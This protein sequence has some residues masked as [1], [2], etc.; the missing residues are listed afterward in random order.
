MRRPLVEILYF[1]GCPNHE[2]SRELVE[3][4]AAELRLQPAIEMVE[5]ADPEAAA[6]LRF[7]GSPS[8]RVDGRDV[9]PAAEQRDDFALA[10]RVYLSERGTA[11]Q[12]GDALI[13]EAL[14]AAAG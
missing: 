1:Q 13:R 8:V 7:L 14:A 5:V 10:C 2:R 3:R 9:E 6:R 11:G 4:I 12:P